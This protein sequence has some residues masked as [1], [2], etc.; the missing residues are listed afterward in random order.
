M[1]YLDVDAIEMLKRDYQTAKRVLRSST[2]QLER[3]KEEQRTQINTIRRAVAC[4]LMEREW[5]AQN[6]AVEYKGLYDP[7]VNI[8]L[9]E[10]PNYQL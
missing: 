9:G 8:A 2:P 10:D 5:K 1:P 4:I 6:S 7:E 3:T